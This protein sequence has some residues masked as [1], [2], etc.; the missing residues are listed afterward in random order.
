[1]NHLANF[2]HYNPLKLKLKVFFISLYYCYGNL[3]CHERGF[4]CSATLER[5]CDTITRN[6]TTG[7]S[8][9]KW[10]NRYAHQAHKILDK[11]LPVIS[12]IFFFCDRRHFYQT[13]TKVSVGV[14]L[15]CLL[16]DLFRNN[17]RGTIEKITTDLD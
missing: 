16:D 12:I 3:L 15:C 10:L 2:L 13:I 6:S 11:E 5:L 1:M 17:V 7:P 9:N 8:K 4:F 14:S